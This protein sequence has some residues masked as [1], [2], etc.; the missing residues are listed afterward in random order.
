MNAP[1]REHRREFFSVSRQELP[2]NEKSTIFRSRGPQP[3]LEGIVHALPYG[4][5]SHKQHL[6]SALGISRFAARVIYVLII[7]VDV[8]RQLLAG[9]TFVQKG[10]H[11]EIR[12]AQ[13]TRGQLVLFFLSMQLVCIIG[14]LVIGRQIY[15]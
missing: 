6:Q 14:V 9:I 15:T 1:M 8:S 10:L 5:Y 11:Y 7:A 3:C 4:A 13:E 12:W 2:G